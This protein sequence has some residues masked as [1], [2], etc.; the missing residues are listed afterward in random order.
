MQSRRRLLVVTLL[1]VL[2]V[3]AIFLVSR[4]TQKHEAKDLPKKTTVKNVPQEQNQGQ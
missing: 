3:A 1:I 2:A 4:V